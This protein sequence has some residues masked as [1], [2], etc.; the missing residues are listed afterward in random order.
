M[1][2][3]NWLLRSVRGSTAA[4][5]SAA[6]APQIA[7]APPVSRPSAVDCFMA[8]A[9]HAPK[10]MVSSTA[11]MISSTAVP[12]SAAICSSVMRAPS[13]AT[14]GA[15]HGARGELD[16]RGACADHRPGS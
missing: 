10:A 12:P 7:T 13:R 4:M 5:A 2:R 9:S 15:Q 14:P 11:T 6:E 16:A 3:V 1:S 8:R